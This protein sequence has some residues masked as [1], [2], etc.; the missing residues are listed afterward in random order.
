MT[1]LSDYSFL[2]RACE[3]VYLFMFAIYRVWQVN[4]FKCLHPSRFRNGE[5]KSIVTLMVLICIPCQLY[6]DITSTI[7]KYQEGFL[8]IPDPAQLTNPLADT[9]ITKP[10]MLW[11]PEH[12][13]LVVP[14]DYTLCVGFSLQTG[15]LF[16]LQ[17][18][19]NYLANSVAKANFMGSWEFR[20]Y[21]VWSVVSMAMFPILQWVFSRP[22]AQ[23]Q[24]PNWKE[25][26]PELAYGIEL[27]IIACLGIHSHFRFRRLIHQSKSHANAKQV[28]RRLNYFMEMNKILTF[29]LTLCAASFIILSGDGLTKEMYLNTHKFT[30]D[31]LICNANLLA[32]VVWF[33]LIMIFHPR[34]GYG[35]PGTDT[36]LHTMQK[37]D[38]GFSTN[39]YPAHNE[40]S[41]GVAVSNGPATDYIPYQSQQDTSSLSNTVYSPTTASFNNQ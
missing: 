6:Y 31:L 34:E 11:T 10:E 33:M 21:I 23:L 41:I 38:K 9:I 1:H 19:W 37:E 4:R 22:E 24:N 35:G 15:T 5:L 3:L 28:T 39:G 36:L 14:T 2:Q 27:F 26:V 40:Q 25:I 18:F 8:A 20:L 17:S 32:I 29:C 16:L 12:Q 7:I 30:A 13:S